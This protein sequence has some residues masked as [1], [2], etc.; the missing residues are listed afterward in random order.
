MPDREKVVKG[1]E[2]CIK[3]GESP[4]F[5]CGAKNQCPYEREG[6]ICWISLNRDALELIKEQQR[7]IDVL[8]SLRR[9]EQEGR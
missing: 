8:E 1:L 5:G 7:R 2:I 9:T 3:H 4:T 6:I